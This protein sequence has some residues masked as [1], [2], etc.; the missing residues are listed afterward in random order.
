MTKTSHGSQ[1]ASPV[2]PQFE[3][4]M[5]TSPWKAPYSHLR[6]NSPSLGRSPG[7]ASSRNAGLIREAERILESTSKV[8]QEAMF[9]LVRTKP[10]AP[11]TKQTHQTPITHHHTLSF[12]LS[13]AIRKGIGSSERGGGGSSLPHRAHDEVRVASR[14]SR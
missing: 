7:R 1:T 3:R 9:D 5:L 6:G 13:S 10:H 2:G 4:G 11:H 12:T 8:S 14:R